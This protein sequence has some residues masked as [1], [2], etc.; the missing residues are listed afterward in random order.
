MSA[1]RVVRRASGDVISRQSLSWFEVSPQ[2]VLSNEFDL[3]H[4]ELCPYRSVLTEKFDLV[5]E[6]PLTSAQLCVSAFSTDCGFRDGSEDNRLPSSHRHAGTVFRIEAAAPQS[7]SG[8]ESAQHSP[9]QN[10]QPALAQA[11]VRICLDFS[12][13]RRGGLIKVYLDLQGTYSASLPR[14]VMPKRECLFQ[15][16]ETEA[17][18]KPDAGPIMVSM[19]PDRILIVICGPGHALR[20]AVLSFRISREDTTGPQRRGLPSGRAP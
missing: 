17:G 5:G 12:Y 11:N 7:G 8:K 4:T 10:R 15:P 6:R 20:V 19:G 13:S 3:K 18:I 14:P 9:Q 16:L 1:S 2:G